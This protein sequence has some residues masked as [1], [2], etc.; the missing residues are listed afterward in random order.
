MTTDAPDD[1]RRAG[2]DL[3]TG[4]SDA[5]VL[6]HDALGSLMGLSA[7][8]HKALGILRREGPMSASR[9]AG[10][11]GLTP[12]AV[13]GLVDRLEAVGLAGRERDPEDRRRLVVA[14]TA[15]TSPDVLAALQGLGDAMAGVTAQFTDAE[16]AVVARWVALTTDALRGQVDAIARR[17]DA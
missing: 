3:G 8:D 17:R 12:G 11:T 7:A 5:V 6:F 14:A 16:L 10:R 15:P 13:T 2:D 1:D 9:L 4:L